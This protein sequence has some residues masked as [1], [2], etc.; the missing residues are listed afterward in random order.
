MIAL[1]GRSFLNLALSGNPGVSVSTVTGTTSTQ[2]NSLFS[3]FGVGRNGDS[4]KTRSPS[5]GSD[6]NGAQLDRR[7]HGDATS[8]RKWCKE[9]R[10]SSTIY[11]FRRALFVGSINIVFAFCGNQFHGSATFSC[12]AITTWPPIR[13]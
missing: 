5:D 1:N 13:V 10:L 6:G 2:Y 8:R 12:S 4:N 9:F 3:A 7:K 11:D